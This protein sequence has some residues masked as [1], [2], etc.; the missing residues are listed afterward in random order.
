MGWATG[1]LLM[2]LMVVLVYGMIIGWMSWR[3]DKNVVPHA[4]DEPTLTSILDEDHEG[5][6]DDPPSVNGLT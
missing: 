1:I 5:W 3:T 6:R 2:I 4:S